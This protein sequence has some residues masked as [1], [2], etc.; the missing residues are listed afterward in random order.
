MRR[1]C[2]SVLAIP[3]AGGPDRQRQNQNDPSSQHDS[4][5]IA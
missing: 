2:I 3:L 5:V 4:P 1:R